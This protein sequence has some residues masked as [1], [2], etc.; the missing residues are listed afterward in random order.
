MSISLYHDSAAA[1]RKGGIDGLVGRDLEGREAA[2][3]TSK[4]LRPKPSK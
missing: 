2:Q 3:T 1:E 4:S